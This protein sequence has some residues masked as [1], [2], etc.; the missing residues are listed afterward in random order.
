MCDDA[1]IG[2]SRISLRFYELVDRLIVLDN[3]STRNPM[4]PLLD[5]ERGRVLFA[6]Q[7]LPKWLNAALREKIPRRSKTKRR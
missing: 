2:A 7:P 5:V 4:R 3:S 1:I 6:R